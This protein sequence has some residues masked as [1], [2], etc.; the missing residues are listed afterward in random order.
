MSSSRTHAGQLVSTEDE[1]FLLVRELMTE[2]ITETTLEDR[3]SRHGVLHGRVLG[4]GTRRRAAQSFA[5]LAGCLEILVASYEQLPLS[6]HEAHEVPTSETPFGLA[7]I[8]QAMAFLPVRSVYLNSQRSGHDV[9]LQSSSPNRRANSRISLDSP[10]RMPPLS[11]RTGNRW[12]SS[13]EAS[14]SRSIS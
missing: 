10:T 12:L 14:L 13:P 1:F 6:R 11:K 9:S 5:F 4:Y 8:L 7:L 3:P 2:S